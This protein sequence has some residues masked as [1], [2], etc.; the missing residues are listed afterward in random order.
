MSSDERRDVD[1]GP[2]RA[3]RLW[4]GTAMFLMRRIFG[5]K[6]HAR[7]IEPL[8]AADQP[9]VVVANHTG[10][11]EPFLLAHAVWQRTGHWIQPLVK[12]EIF[13]L[14]I[15]GWLARAAGAIPVERGSE[16]GRASAYAA[17]VERLHEGGAIYIAPEGTTSHDGELL[18][19]RHGAAR[20][21]L[22][23]GCS[24]MVVTSF[25]GQRAFSQVV[26]RPHR[27]AHFDLT[28]EALVP[29]EDDDERSLTGRVAATMIDRGAE[30]RESYGQRD[31]TAKWWPPYRDPAEP[32]KTA[33]EN[34][35]QYREAMAEAI[36]QARER[37]T[38]LAAER[39]LD[40]RMNAA[41]ERA[42]EAAEQAR[43]RAHELGDQLRH[44]SDELL[45]L[46]RQGQLGEDMRHRVE[47][48]SRQARLVAEHAAELREELREGAEHH[49]HDD[50]PG[51]PPSHDD[52]GRTAPLDEVDGPAE[53]SVTR[54]SSDDAA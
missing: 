53:P 8:P 37:M 14:P 32:T 17:A 27:G 30:L 16:H 52:R 9:V 11:V 50:E 5:W 28:I 40:G 24:M 34:M 29:M 26:G 3:W 12:A 19:L 7:V 21:A 18:P 42:R 36:E 25:G 13:K 31:I 35:E 10:Y 54:S 2:S 22:Q 1:A 44:R 41:R 49:Q 51:L 20:L 43:E 23:A 33:R 47:E 45:D 6:F 39:D 46:A 15:A 38:S 4:I 48:L